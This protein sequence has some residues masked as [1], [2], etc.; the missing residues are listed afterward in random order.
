MHSE[1]FRLCIFFCLFYCEM[2]ILWSHLFILLSSKHLFLDFSRKYK[3]PVLLKL[4]P[5]SRVFTKNVKLTL[6]GSLFHSEI[7][8][9]DLQRVAMELSGKKEAKVLWFSENKCPFKSTEESCK[10]IYPNSSF[11]VFCTPFFLWLQ[12]NVCVLL[13]NF[14]LS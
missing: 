11:F 3:I 13:Y 2:V 8:W 14:K 12:N 5:L 1:K 4:N 9:L 7:S 10:I 6:S